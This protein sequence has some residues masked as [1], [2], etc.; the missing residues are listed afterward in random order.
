MCVCARVCV[1]MCVWGVGGGERVAVFGFLY[2][3]LLGSSI[4]S[5]QL[6]CLNL[7]VKLLLYVLY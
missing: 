7:K 1:C 4:F 5:F 2:F 3:E 6:L